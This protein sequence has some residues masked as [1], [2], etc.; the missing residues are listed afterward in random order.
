M[1]RCPVR[2]R[3]VSTVS[4]VVKAVRCFFGKRLALTPEQLRIA[5]RILRLE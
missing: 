1:T 3:A 5:R 4:R 2:S